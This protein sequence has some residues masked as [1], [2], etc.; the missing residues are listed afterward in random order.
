MDWNKG[1]SARYYMTLVDP[2]SWRDT[3]R[4]EI[5]SGNISRSG[6]S[7]MEAADFEL[8]E[9]PPS[10]SWIRIYLDARQTGD[11][12]REALF[13]GILSAPSVS[14]N[15]VIKTYRTECYSVLKPAADMLMQRGW[16]AP[17]EMNGAELA[18]KLLSIG[19]LQVEYEDNAPTLASNIVAEDGESNLTMAHKILDAIGWRIRITGR[20]EINICPQADSVS[21]TFDALENDSIELAV[22]DSHDWFG[23]PNVFR[24]V[25]DD[26]TAIARDDDEDSPLSTVSRGRE[27]WMEESSANLNENESIAEYAVR[28][29][30]E[31]QSLAREISYTRRFWP[32]LY[33][34]DIVRIHHPAQ[35]ID[36]DFR[37]NSQRIELTHG[38]R[39]AEGAVQI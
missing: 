21:Q 35:N 33:I 31:E 37:I 12:A 11:D 39:T 22:T 5:V 19:T 20:G 2:V 4:I 28:R 25:S 18:A 38:G 29:L 6:G 23:C 1:F 16:Y 7:L 17:A 24:A 34:G 3:E 32:D 30:K 27:I 14:W 36:A 9:L 15:G 26:L 8:T 10:D 13:T